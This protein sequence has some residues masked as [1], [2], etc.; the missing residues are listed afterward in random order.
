ME[1]LKKVCACCI[2]KLHVQNFAKNYDG[3]QSWCRKCHS[4]YYH[5]RTKV[6]PEC[7]REMPYNAFNKRASNPDGHATICRRCTKDKR[8]GYHKKKEQV[9]REHEVKD[10]NVIDTQMKID[11]NAVKVDIPEPIQTELEASMA[12]TSLMVDENKMAKARMIAV[13]E[14]LTISN[15]VNYALGLAIERYE[16]LHGV[17][18]L[19]TQE[20]DI[21]KIFGK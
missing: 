6:C 14:H 19:D 1:N 11:F 2:R 9:N 3:L 7:G 8:W 5:K 15:I 20:K 18:I 16:S 17:I 12:R 21:R 4:D 13:R 10:L